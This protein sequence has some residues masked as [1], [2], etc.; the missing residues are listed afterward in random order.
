MSVK[1]GQDR[2]GDCG[3]WLPAEDPRPQGTERIP[4][5]NCGSTK[6]IK[7]GK[8]NIRVSTS[9]AADAKLIISWHEVDRLLSEEEYAAAVLVAAVNVEFILWENLRHLSP[10]TL[11]SKKTHYSK[12]RTWQ[13]I[14]KSDRDSVGL[15][16]LIQLAQFFT[17]NKESDLQPSMDSFAW[18]LNEVRKGIAHKR[19][20]FARLTQLKE[21]DW[22]E[23]RIRQVL[24]DAKAF[25][26]GNAP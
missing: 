16:S 7:Y 12:W 25:C 24:K 10:A 4:C 11:P 3:A 8:S 2:C 21:G 17:A 23:S 1:R 19:G 26:H 15:G 14:G 6:R 22:P 18:P 20:Y 13:A 9:V 5:P